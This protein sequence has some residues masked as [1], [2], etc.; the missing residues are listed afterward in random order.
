MADPWPFNSFVTSRVI[1]ALIKTFTDECWPVPI[2][3]HVSSLL[4]TIEHLITLV[5]IIVFYVPIQL[6]RR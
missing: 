6:S 4:P 3:V 2:D 5:E 1:H